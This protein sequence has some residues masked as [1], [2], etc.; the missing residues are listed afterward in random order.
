MALRHGINTYKDATDFTVVKQAKVSIPFFVG[1]WP[2]HSGKGFTDKP[3][4]A[5]S[6]SEAKELGG[7]SSEWRYPDGSP[8]WTLC[9]AMY[10]HFKIFNMSP[11]I[12]Y[13][14]YNPAK[15]KKAVPA[16][17]LAV[18]DHIVIITDDVIDDIGLVVK[19]DSDTLVR[20]TDYEV[21]YDDGT[22]C[23]EILKESA[24]YSATTLSVAYNAADLS[25]ITHADIEEA[26]EQVEYCRSLFGVVPDLLAA[27]GWTQIPS[28]AAILSAKAA[29]INSLYKAKAVVDIDTSATGAD[30]YSKVLKWKNDNGYTDKNEIVCWPLVTVG[31]YVFDLS[32]IAIGLMAQVDSGNADCPYESPSN[33]GLSIT[34]AVNAAGTE[35]TLSL[36]QADVISVT[37]GVVTILN[38]GGWTLWGN[39]TGCWPSNSDVADYFICTNRMM[40]WICN[41]FVDTYWSFVD[42]P[43]TRVIIDAMVDSFNSWLNGLAHEGKIYDG[44]IKYISDNNPTA[45]I[46]GG[47]F[48]LDTKVASPI[49]LQQIDMHAQFS[50]DMLTAALS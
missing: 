28:V 25:S 12:V 22:C 1:A 18:V 40:D 37:D 38:N 13:N 36:P 20:D 11:I 42:K 16:A 31:D 47:Q 10:S 41:T 21:Y 8:K 24:A 3:Q 6:Y 19:N 15:H 43:A 29:S 4:M 35:I 32:V 2:C 48:R 39:Y 27:P 34:G 50:V 7:Y 30:E 44:E 9:Q 33:K 5:Y 45:N 23:I 26:I 49:P 17:D 14:V 46:L